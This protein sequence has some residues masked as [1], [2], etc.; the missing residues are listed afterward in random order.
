MVL[1]D[2]LHE[3]FRK[4]IGFWFLRKSGLLVRK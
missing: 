4:P 2:W 3:R 1:I